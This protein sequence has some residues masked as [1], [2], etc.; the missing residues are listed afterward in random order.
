M[1]DCYGRKRDLESSLFSKLEAL[2]DLNM[3]S[4]LFSEIEES[5]T[6]VEGELNLLQF[7]FD[8]GFSP[9]K[10]LQAQQ[11]SNMLLKEAAHGR[12]CQQAKF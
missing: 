1:W 10:E 8:A 5:K 6:A 7:A 11:A 4:T 3:E 9:R 2:T 12:I